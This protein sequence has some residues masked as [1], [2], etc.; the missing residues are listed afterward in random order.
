[1]VVGITS[2][3]NTYQG[4][5]RFQGLLL[6]MPLIGKVYRNYLIVRVSTTL[7]LLLGAG[8]PIVKTLR[9]T[10]EASNNLLYEEA[11]TEISNEVEKGM[12]IAAS[13]EKVDPLHDL[14][15]QDFIQL[16]SA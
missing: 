12:K 5:K 10:G 16:L 11:I 9:L 3:I 14:F 13:F 15:T 4:R 6:V 8:I 1:M 2:Y 7:G